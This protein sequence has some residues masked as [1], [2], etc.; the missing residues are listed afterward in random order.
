MLLADKDSKANKEEGML[1]SREGAWLQDALIWGLLR[2]TAETGLTS[3]EQGV[4]CK[5][6]TVDFFLAD[7]VG[8][9]DQN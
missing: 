5:R 2:D 9:K 8:M 3:S 1:P 6:F 4:F 7:A